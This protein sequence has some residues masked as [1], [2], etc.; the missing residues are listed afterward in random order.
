[1]GV[2]CQT[3]EVAL[4]GGLVSVL[5]GYPRWRGR[6]L[7]EGVVPDGVRSVRVN[8]VGGRSE[9]A[10]VVRNA[11]SI[12]ATRPADVQYTGTDSRGR[13]FTRTVT[14]ASFPG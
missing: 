14:V 9:T 5:S 6:A 13:S 4:A 1:M 7:I 3:P 12:L 10:R 8:A 11:Y 2:T